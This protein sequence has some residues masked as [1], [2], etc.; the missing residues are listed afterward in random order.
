MSD[1]R[2]SRRS[3]AGAQAETDRVIDQIA[4]EMTEGELPGDFRAR[5]VARIQSP[6]EPRTTNS[7][8]SRPWFWI[9]APVAA[10]IVVAIFLARESR[11]SAPAVA[12]PQSA[13]V[14]RA[15]GSKE[16]PAVEPAQAPQRDAGTTARQRPPRAIAQRAIDPSDVE[17]LAPPPLVAPSIAI[18]TLTTDSLALEELELPAP[19]AIAPLATPEGEQR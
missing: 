7:G 12:H 10:A 5:V 3:A 13:A 4:R 16:P 17:A 6:H 9:L 11:E 1:E 19:I 15:Q 2:Q 14:A 8:R 18:R